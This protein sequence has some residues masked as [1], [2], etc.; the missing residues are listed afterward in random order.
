MKARLVLA[1]ACAVSLAV[2]FVAAGGADNRSDS[3]PSA[4]FMPPDKLPVSFSLPQAVR[5]TDGSVLPA[6]PYDVQ[7]H[8]KGFGNAAELWF[9]QQGQLKGKNSAEVRGVPSTAPGVATGETIV[10]LQKASSEGKVFPKSEAGDKWSPA[11]APGAFA[12]DKAGFRA[13]QT[14]VVTPAGPRMLKLSFDSANSAAGF[15]VN[16]PYFEKGRK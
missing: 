16:L 9:F 6:G 7:I 1:A 8:Y 5:L 11:G 3:P 14:G 12:W 15:F 10:K 13:G 2:S 4:R